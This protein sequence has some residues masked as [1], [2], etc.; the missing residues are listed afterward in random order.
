MRIGCILATIGIMGL[1]GLGSLTAGAQEHERRRPT[2]ESAKQE[3]GGAEETERNTWQ[4]K[5]AD[6]GRVSVFNV[7]GSI[8]VTGAPGDAVVVEAIKRTRGSRDELALVH[9]DIFQRP[10]R[11]DIR[12]RHTMPR[13]DGVSVD[14]TVSVPSAATLNLRSVSGDV[15]VLNVRGLV[16]AESI[17]GGVLTSNVPRVEF[18]KSVSGSVEIT[19]T[20]TDDAELNAAST[21]G[22]VRTVGLRARRLR[23]NTVTGDLIL[24][25]ITCEN[26]DARSVTG[27]VEYAGTLARSGHYEISS[28]SGPIRLALTGDVGFDLSAE[29]FS[30]SV[31]SDWPLNAGGRGQ[32][33]RLQHIMQGTFGDGSAAINIS[34]FSGDVV[35]VKRE[36]GR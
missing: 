8:S 22:T 27:K 29:S 14:Y 7:A 13:R 36:A 9:T 31:R 11:I 10:G 18:A 15:K 17:S 3:R 4:M 25:D 23:L 34:T 12:T 1:S 16:R 28:H 6:D 30:G 5:L 2:R 26:L 24:G 33:L 20:S 19:N 35:I 32:L 21:T